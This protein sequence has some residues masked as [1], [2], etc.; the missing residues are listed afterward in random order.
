MIELLDYQETPLGLLCL[1]RRELLSRPGIIVTEV[2][3]D[4]VFLMSSYHTESER[5]L[6]SRALEIHQGNDNLEILVGGLGLGFTALEALKDSRTSK[7]EVIEI[8]PQVIQW[9]AE[10]WI[11]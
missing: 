11:P 4:H 9:L 2:T 8:L 5:A 1:R 3:L 6:A 7:V 10:G